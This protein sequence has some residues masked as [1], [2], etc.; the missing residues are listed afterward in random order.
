MKSLLNKWSTEKEMKIWKEAIFVFDT[1]VLLNFLEFLHSYRQDIYANIFSKLSGRLFITNYAEYEFLKNKEKVLNNPKEEYRIIR[2]KHFPDQH[3]QKFV[4]Q[5]QQLKN[6]T[7]KEDRHPYFKKDIFSEMDEQLELLKKK[8][9]VLV[10]LMEQFME[11]QLEEHASS[12]ED[13]NLL[14]YFEVT[15]TYTHQE[16]MKIAEEG[17]FRYRHCMPPGYMDEKEKAN[18][19]ISKFGDLICWKQTLEL[20][21]QKNRPVLLICDDLKEDWCITDSKDKRKLVS[22]RPEL[23]KEMK[24][25]AG[26]QMW[27]YSSPQFLH[28]SKK[29]LEFDVDKEMIKYFA[30]KVALGNPTVRNEAVLKFLIEIYES[31]SITWDAGGSMTVPDK[32][33][34]QKGEVKMVVVVKRVNENDFNSIIENSLLLRRSFKVYRKTLYVYVYVAS[35][36]LMAEKIASEIRHDLSR[37]IVYVGYLD[38][39]NSFCAVGFPD[40]DAE[41]M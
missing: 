6:L 38:E 41:K 31:E 17:E 18:L 24:D 21:K 2:E 25:I 15:P 8:S 23:I 30:E 22:P 40:L 16:L 37:I 28:L 19:G 36:E 33:Y 13:D 3:L 27:S 35:D 29:I 1:S 26:V 11:K 20:A 34:M 4:N 10:S 9:E 12:I 32:F 39:K 14:D 7:A 5:Y